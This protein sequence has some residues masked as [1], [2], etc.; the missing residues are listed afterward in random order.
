MTKEVYFLPNAGEFTHD[1][2][3]AADEWS[4]VAFQLRDA[5]ERIRDVPV[6]L[7][8][9]R[10]VVCLDEILVE[11]DEALRACPPQIY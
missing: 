4:K 5:L 2:A 9:N 1:A 6:K 10:P 7:I 8:K 3:E 11:A